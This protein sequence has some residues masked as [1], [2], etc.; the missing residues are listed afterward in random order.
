M[1][2]LLILSGSTPGMRSPT[3]GRFRLCL[4]RAST[5]SYALVA[6]LLTT[7]A[8][9][10]GDH[11]V[12]GTARVTV[13][14]RRC[15]ES[16]DVAPPEWAWWRRF[17][18]LTGDLR[19]ALAVDIRDHRDRT[20]GTELV[21]RL[22]IRGG[23]T[24]S[25]AAWVSATARLAAFFD[26]EADGVGF[27]LAHR[28]TIESGDF[29]FDS[30]FL[31]LRP[32]GLLTIRIGRL[33]TQFEIDSVVRDSLSRNDSGGL[34]VTWTD[35]AH[36]EIGRP[37]SFRLHLIGQLN[38]EEGPTNGVGTRGPIELDDDA[39]RVT[40]YA[41]LEAPRWGP[42]TQLVTDVTIIPEALR[43]QGLET[44]PRES[45]A[46]LTLKAAADFPV[47]D[48]GWALVFHPFVEAGAMLTTPRENAVGVSTS[49]DRAGR[50]AIVAGMDFKRLGPGDLGIQFGW[51]EA[52]YLIAPDYPNNTWSIEAR[53]KVGLVGNAVLEVR[54]RQRQEIGRLVD[55]L[56]READHNILARI[57]LRY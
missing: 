24:V 56:D 14:D 38:P 35:G 45:V 10:A 11:L 32:H 34:D 39:S 9:G 43:P 54:Y 25:P 12:S 28:R 50:F 7:A 27:R 40:Y 18:T 41:A 26:K 49:A 23:F 16:D 48:G 31:T 52:G 19:A 30:L 20:D 44:A 6:G 3:R 1:F 42:L 15:A 51:I 8:A 29:T 37:D 55:A 57:T 17:V 2:R 13:C 47:R 33:Q 5:T 21:P 53:Y 46:A 36:L 4:I 22:R